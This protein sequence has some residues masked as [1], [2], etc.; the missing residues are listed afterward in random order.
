MNFNLREISNMFAK[1]LDNHVIDYIPPE[2][3]VDKSERLK[4]RTKNGQLGMALVGA[5]SSDPRMV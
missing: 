4:S 2:V 1:V 5:L 3:L